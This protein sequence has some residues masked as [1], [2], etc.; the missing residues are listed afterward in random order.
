MESQGDRVLFHFVRSAQYRVVHVDGAVGAPTPRGLIH[1]S[2]YSERQVIPDAV[3]QEILPDGRLTD[4]TDMSGPIGIMR[5]LEVGVMMDETTAASFHHWLGQQLE[6][7][8]SRN[9]VGGPKPP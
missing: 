2:L 6:L 1:I 7:L 8:R 3:V 5:E 9:A 4:V